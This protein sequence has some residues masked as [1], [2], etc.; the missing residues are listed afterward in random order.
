[1]EETIES[2]LEYG[3]RMNKLYEYTVNEGIFNFNRL[4][5]EKEEIEHLLKD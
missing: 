2:L 3:S 1:M 4:K 5:Q